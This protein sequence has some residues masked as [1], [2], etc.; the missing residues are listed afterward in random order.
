MRNNHNLE[1]A[2]ADAIKKHALDDADGISTLMT[3]AAAVSKRL[4]ITKDRFLSSCQ[5]MADVLWGSANLDERG[6]G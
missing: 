4:G 5:S 1:R 3:M 2:I 6:M